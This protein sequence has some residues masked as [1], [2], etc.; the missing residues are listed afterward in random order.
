MNQQFKLE[1]EKKISK[2]LLD[3]NWADEIH[4]DRN[5]WYIKWSY[6]ATSILYRIP[7][8]LKYWYDMNETDFKCIEFMK[9]YFGLM[10]Q[11]PGYDELTLNMQES[12][13]GFA[14]RKLSKELPK[15]MTDK[16]RE[17]KWSY[18]GLEMIIDSINAMN[19]NEIEGYIMRL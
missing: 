18:M 1:N 5:D 10:L 3:N 4:W 9:S 16:I 17:N 8:I 6:K 11:N 7:S 12:A 2:I 19:Q 13:I 15:E 14:L